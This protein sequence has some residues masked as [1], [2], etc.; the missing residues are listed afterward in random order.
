MF[1]K[2]MK[3]ILVSFIDVL[4]Y[5][6]IVI[7]GIL[8]FKGL[9]KIILL[10]LLF[11]ILGRGTFVESKEFSYLDSFQAEYINVAAPIRPI[12]ASNALEKFPELSAHSVFVVDLATNKVLFERN[13][14]VRFAPASTTKLMTALISQE[15]YSRN[16]LLEIPSECAQIEGMSAGFFDGEQVTYSDLLRAT[17]IGSANDAACTLARSKIPEKDFIDQMNIRAVELGMLDTFFT[18]PVGFDSADYGH[19]S[20]ARDLYKLTLAVRKD[21]EIREILSLKNYVV[22][23]GQIIRRVAS[24]NQ[25]LWEIPQSVGI[26]TGTTPQAGEVLIYEYKDSL[27]NKDLLII[28]MNSENRF[29]ETRKILAWILRKYIWF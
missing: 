3:K 17:L 11:F 10:F 18:N 6:L 22:N 21:E 5:I 16:E 8:S 14:E 23:S 27:E 25:L 28:L 2:I 12:R 24:T 9:Y 29:D 15:L 26:K 20:T 19:Y 1:K 13:S 4:L 7:G